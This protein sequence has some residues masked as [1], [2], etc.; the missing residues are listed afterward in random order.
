[1]KK[2]LRTS[3]LVLTSLILFLSACQKDDAPVEKVYRINGSMQVDGRERT[4]LVN[5][6]PNYYEGGQFSLVIGMHGGGGSGVQFETS[7]L[8][9]QKANASGFVVVYPDGVQSDG[10][11]KART[12]NAGTCCDYAVEKNIDDIKF[13]SNL[14]DE[15]TR[16]YSINPKKVYATGHSNGGMMSYRLACQLSNKI[17]AIAPNGCTMVVTTPCNPARPVPVLHMHSELD[18]KVPYLGGYGDGVGTANLVLPSLDSVLNVW[19]AI[20]TCGKKGEVITQNSGYTFRKWSACSNNHTLEYYLTKDGGH[21]W[22]GGLP[23]GPF[24]DPTSQV[25]K[26]ND[27]LWEFFQKFQLP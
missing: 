6:P 24:S 4:Y 3:Y 21:G 12:W 10:L 22:P 8:L 13:I 17:A 23:G 20:N 11:L 18:K 27:L 14:I 25:I 16:K 1:M 7:S 26:A 2:G 15:L 9:T 5:L 19:S